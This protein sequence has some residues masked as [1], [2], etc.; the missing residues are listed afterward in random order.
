MSDT[1]WAYGSRGHEDEQTV[2]GQRRQF[3]SK[4]AALKTLF[5]DCAPP[6]VLQGPYQSVLDS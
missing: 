2:A 4:T 1:S 5:E 6:A 3:D